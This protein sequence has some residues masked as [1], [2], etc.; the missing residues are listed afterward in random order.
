[1]SPHTKS[2]VSTCQEGTEKD[3]IY[4]HILQFTYTELSDWWCLVGLY[5]YKS[6]CKNKPLY[7]FIM[8]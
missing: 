7:V 4:R 2:F 3:D 1:M 8:A 5:S 6:K